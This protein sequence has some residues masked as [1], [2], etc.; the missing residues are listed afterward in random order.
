MYWCIVL[1]K[2]EFSETKL[3]KE[4]NLCEQCDDQE[5]DRISRNDALDCIGER[6]VSMCPM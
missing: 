6:G 5:F 3:Q 4:D 1:N 2:F